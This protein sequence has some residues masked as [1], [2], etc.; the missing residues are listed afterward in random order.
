MFLA[1]LW[2]GIEASQNV[3]CSQ[4]MAL[5][6]REE[7]FISVCKSVRKLSKAADPMFQKNNV[8]CHGQSSDHDSAGKF[9]AR[10]RL[11]VNLLA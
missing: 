4:C 2:H 3:L 8:L 9:G 6:R 11:N 7:A 5:R 1:Q 10:I